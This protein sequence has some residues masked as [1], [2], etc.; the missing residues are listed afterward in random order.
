MLNSLKKMF[1]R[2][3][4]SPAIAE[5]YR[6][7]V[8]QARQPVF[9]TDAHVPDSVDGRFD[10][11]I[12]HVLLVIDRLID[13]PDE[14]QQLFD[15]L[16]A[17][18]DKNLREMG[19][20]DVSIAKKMKPMLAAFYGRAKAYEDAMKLDDASLADALRKNIYGKATPSDDDVTRLT[21]Y[22]RAAHQALAAQD[23]QALLNGT[24]SFPAL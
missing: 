5:I 8:A 15:I 10:L 17:D 12:L 3:I 24:I 9:Y 14:T 11:L 2:P 1:L 16:F 20:S 18:M 7:C 6:G 19:V 23:T 4:A 22:V 21:A 13:H